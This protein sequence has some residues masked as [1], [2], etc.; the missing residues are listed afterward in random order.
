MKHIIYLISKKNLNKAKRN[1]TFFF[2]FVEWNLTLFSQKLSLRSVPEF[3][4]LSHRV[5]FNI[6][7]ARISHERGARL[8]QIGPIGLR[9]ALVRSILHNVNCSPRHKIILSENS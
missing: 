8:R 9:P 4:V 5:F 1:Y 6:T 3:C 7:N 2:V